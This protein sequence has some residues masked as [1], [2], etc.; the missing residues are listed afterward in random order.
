[1][2]VAAFL[3]QAA[4]RIEI[5]GTPA[6][7]GPTATELREAA[8]HL[9]PQRLRTANMGNP[10]TL[11]VGLEPAELD[12]LRRLE[13]A[14]QAY[15]DCIDEIGT[16]AEPPTEHIERLDVLEEAMRVHLRSNQQ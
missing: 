12:R 6:Q 4:D 13:T 2:N 8:D 3:R 16:S 15:C 7:V 14:V 10:I 5:D 9:D 1:M 11:L